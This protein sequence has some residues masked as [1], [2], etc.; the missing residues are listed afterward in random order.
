MR[1]TRK[2][3]LSSPLSSGII[4]KSKFGSTIKTSLSPEKNEKIVVSPSI[5]LKFGFP[6]LSAKW[7][8][9]RD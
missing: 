6:L 4:I 8:L 2:Y 9:K 7:M 1:E 5:F 3:S